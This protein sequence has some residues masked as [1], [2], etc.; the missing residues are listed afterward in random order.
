[1]FCAAANAAWAKP[2]LAAEVARGRVVT[3]G[4]NPQG[5]DGLPI[6]IDCFGEGTFETQ[7]GAGGYFS[8]D[9]P[10]PGGC[11]VYLNGNAPPGTQIYWNN[12]YLANRQGSWSCVNGSC[13]LLVFIVGLVPC[14]ARS[15]AGVSSAASSDWAA[16]YAAGGCGLLKLSVHANATMRAGLSVIPDENTVHAANFFKNGDT[17]MCLSG[18]ET[19]SVAVKKG[20]QAASPA[21]VTA[22]LAG[23]VPL[24]KDF[25]KPLADYGG[26]SQPLPYVCEESPNTSE[27]DPNC[28]G[29]RLSEATTTNGTTNFVFWTPGVTR[30]GYAIAVTL[31]ASSG[32]L[33]SSKTITI[34]VLPH[35]LTWA[36][37]AEADFKAQFKKT[38][39]LGAM[40][41]DWAE[42]SKSPGLFE[43]LK[44]YIAGK[45][46]SVS[47]VIDAALKSVDLTGPASA[48]GWIEKAASAASQ[49]Q[50]E[51]DV[52]GLVLSRFGV[53]PGGLESGPAEVLSRFAAHWAGQHVATDFYT[54]GLLTSYGDKLAR[55]ESS[56]NQEMD[57]QILEVSYCEKGYNCSIFGHPN[58]VHEYIDFVFYAGD[59]SGTPHPDFPEQLVGSVL[60]PYDAGTW[61]VGNDAK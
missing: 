35:D 28:S 18:C 41:V 16:S 3:E 52:T 33:T 12:W 20:S 43:S 58:G 21:T 31:R 56:I 44:N 24:D 29:S 10:K 32:R 45:A 55:D 39:D 7:T 6:K 9:V 38:D 11:I 23:I 8:I 25:P 54:T 14:G 36:H 51:E 19:I 22:T 50:A 37:H 40:L 5:P 13:R 48:L 61:M 60:V 57:L 1:L 42:S 27:T 34:K 53:T 30:G 49:L 17:S 46:P 26:G 4:A 47:S 15:P 2:Q 59:P